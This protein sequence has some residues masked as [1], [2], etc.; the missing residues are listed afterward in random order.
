MSLEYHIPKSI[1][2]AVTLF[3]YGGKKTAYL[4]GGT[5]L[6]CADRFNRPVNLISLSDLSLSGISSEGIFLRL[7]STTTL[8]DLLSK[9]QVPS[10]LSQ[11]ALGMANRNIRNIATI[12][13]NIGAG[14]SCSSLIPPLLVLEAELDVA[15]EDSVKRLP[16]TDYLESGRQDLILAVLIDLKR[17]EER[18][19]I[20]RKLSRVSN[21]LS[22]V[23]IAIS[24]YK[25]KGFKDPIIIGGGLGSKVVRLKALEDF[26]ASASDVPSE[27]DMA[28]YI[29]M[30]AAP[31][32]DHRGSSQFK[33][34]TAAA[35]TAESLHRIKGVI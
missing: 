23:S 29:Q 16:L 22:L 10:V 3:N 4:A 15:L 13:G 2:E 33:L 35:L 21:D 34:W 20:Y 19:Q 17:A 11:A 12:G 26:I 9:E 6:N 18:A 27:K 8:Q 5:E 25:G 31:I 30:D 24:I 14:K 7:G 28:A 1:S 32:T